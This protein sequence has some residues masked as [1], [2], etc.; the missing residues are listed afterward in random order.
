MI[1]NKWFKILIICLLIGFLGLFSLSMYK[2]ERREKVEKLGGSEIPW[3]MALTWGE[4]YT[5][6]VGIFGQLQGRV[7]ENVELYVREDKAYFLLPAYAE[8]D[9]MTLTF[10]EAYYEI[11]VGERQIKDGDGIKEIFADCEGDLQENRVELKV[12]YLSEAYGRIE[13]TYEFSVRKSQKLPAMF[14][15]TGSGSTENMDK[16]KNNSDDGIF[17]CMDE[18]GYVDSAS[19]IS[20]M[21]AKGQSSFDMAKKNYKLKLKKGNSIL[22]MDSD[23]EYILIA[24]A[25]DASKLRNAMA[26][27]LAKELD[28]PC[29][30]EY[31]YVDLYVNHKY[32]GN[33]MLCQPIDKKYRVKTSGSEKSFLLE[34]ETFKERL[35]P[36]ATYLDRGND[37]YLEIVEPSKPNEAL[38]EYATEVFDKLDEIIYGLKEEDSLLELSKYAD[39]DSFVSAYVMNALTNDID[40]GS[41]STF[42]FYDDKTEKMYMGPIWD[43]DKAWGNQ[44]AINGDIRL[45][46]YSYRWPEKLG[47]NA[48]FRSL[49]LDKL[50]SVEAYIYDM[51]DKEAGALGDY[52]L[53]SYEMDRVVNGN[54]IESVVDTGDFEGNRDYL[55]DYFIREYEFTLDR[56]QNVKDYCKIQFQDNT[57]RVMYLK[58]GESLGEES[59]DYLKKMYKTSGFVMEDGEEILPSTIVEKDLLVQSEK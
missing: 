25:L 4:P 52:I 47:E 46:S 49:V 2:M 17:V 1:K 19:D 37:Y 16:D 43:Y 40:S 31:R 38:V 29:V 26:F 24:N 8:P 39:V 13:Q 34:T 57:G 23:K 7:E 12:A 50:K 55:L 5:G 3:P 10:S 27:S 32:Y 14:I 30:T 51:Q 28:V 21:R 45:C 58:K 59:L 48:E 9:L 18:K 56:V 6:Y 15:E 41:H 20:Q 53:A 35:K 36:E 44:K 54:A 42:C 33:Y 11:S 22:G